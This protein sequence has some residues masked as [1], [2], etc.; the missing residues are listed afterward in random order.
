MLCLHTRMGLDG[1]LGSPRRKGGFAFP[2]VFLLAAH[3]RR[4]VIAV[5]ETG[6]DDSSGA[7]GSYRRLIAKT[8][9]RTSDI[10]SKQRAE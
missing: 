6:Y 7:V 2:G 10:P 3:P 1:Q 9:G 5:T 8:I 4:F